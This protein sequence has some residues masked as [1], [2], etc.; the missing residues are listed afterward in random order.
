MYYN[1]GIGSG[2]WGHKG[3]KGKIGGSS[4]GGN[5]PER[6]K[7]GRKL[8]LLYENTKNN[9][10]KRNLLNKI[11]NLLSKKFEENN[12][13]KSEEKRIKDEVERIKR[14]YC[15]ELY[16]PYEVG[17]I[18]HRYGNYY[19]TIRK[20]FDNTPTYI[21]NEDIEVVKELRKFAKHKEKLLKRLNK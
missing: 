15:R 6:V 17:K 18:G 14:I 13:K 8:R 11:K 21:K 3:R 20:K 2:N 19:F 10:G 5:N 4:K 9:D 1:G 7:H 16:N 12:K